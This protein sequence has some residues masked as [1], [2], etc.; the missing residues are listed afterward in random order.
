VSTPEPTPSKSGFRARLAS[1][2]PAAFGGIFALVVVAIGLV[3]IGIGW[4]GAAGSGGQIN[5]VSD[6]R[7][8]LPWLLSGGF[9]GLAIV[10]FGAGLMIVQAAREDRSRLEARLEE[11]AGLLARGVGA[12]AP[13]DVAGLVVAGVASYHSPD[14]RLVDGREDATYLTA[15][16]ARER[17]LAPCRI[18]NPQ[19]AEQP[20]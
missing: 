19:G 9:L 7:A 8:Q 18:C 13:R 6:L 5:Q 11:I 10:V 2:S 15:A 17:G 14:C 20:A 1:F 12:A 4:N 16:E 3:A